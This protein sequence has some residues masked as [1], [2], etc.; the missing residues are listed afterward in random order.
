VKNHDGTLFG[1]VALVAALTLVWA[2]GCSIEVSPGVANIIDE[3]DSGAP[4]G[5]S[6]GGGGAGGEGGAPVDIPSASHAV[7]DWASAGA[8][9]TS[10]KYKMIYS[11]GQ[12]T[13][14]QGTSVSAGHLAHG[15]VIA[16]DGSLP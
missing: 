9:S 3:P 16:E 12:A 5:G 4:D 11:V 7:M 15:G 1:R 10:K 2:S 6:G 13:I 14:Q 8:T